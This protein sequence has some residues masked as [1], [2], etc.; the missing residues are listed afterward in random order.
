MYFNLIHVLPGTISSTIINFITFKIFKTLI[1]KIVNETV[2]QEGL[3]L[4]R[5]ILIIMKIYI[6]MSQFL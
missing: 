5:N 3:E 4:D 6:V 2:V 1:R